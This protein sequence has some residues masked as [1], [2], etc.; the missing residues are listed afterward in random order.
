MA[1]L[2]FTWERSAMNGDEMPEGLPLEEQLAWQTVAHLY[3]R[4]R[5]KLITRETGHTEKGKI[6]YA[7]DLRKRE[8]DADRKLARWHAD[9][10]KAAEGAA[11]TYAKNRTLEN[12]DR[13]YQ[14]LYG[15]L[16][17]KK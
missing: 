2:T 3:G 6:R 12:A 8:A 1:D 10:M 7:L 14:V 11:N 17:T 9:L 13:L 16:P 5:L 4:F 15:M